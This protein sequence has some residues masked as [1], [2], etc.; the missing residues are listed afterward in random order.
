M[1]KSRQI[2][3]R[4]INLIVG[5]LFFSLYAVAVK[6]L[7]QIKRLSVKDE[8]SIAI[9]P[10]IQIVLAGGDRYLAANLAVFRA[11][12]V[13][14]SQ[15]DPQAYEVL[16]RIQED[17]SRLNPSHEDNYYISQAI[18]P[19]NGQVE[20]DIKIQ[21]AATTS[22][23]WDAMPPFF[24]GFDK[25]Y[26]LK[27]P[28][29]GAENVRIAADRSATGNRESLMAMAA[30][31]YEKG[32]DPTVTIGMIKA[33]AASTRDKELKRHLQMR[34]VRVQGLALL[35][36]AAKAF[37]EKNGMPLNNL[38]ELVSSGILKELPKDPLGQG[39]E[40]NS[41]GMPIIAQPKKR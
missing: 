13:G 4:L 28:V 33:M 11:L 8:L 39:Y 3:D 22:R 40:L 6:Q 34:M 2:N 26:F 36:K 30:R 20:A 10:S 19:W 1:L 23:P 27:D 18:L 16:G 31:W 15:L 21:Q 9:P 14:T 35:Q 38:S 32:D 25:Y 7:D 41:N 29:G 5:V 24:L 12:V 37:T 17:A